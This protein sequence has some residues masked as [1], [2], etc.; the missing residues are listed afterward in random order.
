MGKYGDAAVQATN[1]IRQGGYHPRDAWKTAVRHQFPTQKSAREK[2][3]PRAAY[4]GLCEAG[5]VRGWPKVTI[6][7]LY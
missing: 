3:C 6:R 1:L 2:G 7:A 5:I 4:L